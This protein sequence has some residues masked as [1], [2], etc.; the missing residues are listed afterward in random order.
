[1]LRRLLTLLTVLTLACASAQAY[2]PERSLL[3]QS[4]L[5]SPAKTAPR[6]FAAT[7]ATAAKEKSPVSPHSTKEKTLDTE[8]PSN[9]RR[10]YAQQRYYRPNLGR[11]NRIDPWEGDVLNPITLNKYLYAVGNPLRYTDP[12]G[13]QF[14]GQIC[15]AGYMYGHARSDEER[16]QALRHGANASP[17]IGVPVG[18]ALRATEIVQAPIDAVSDAAS[19][20]AGDE[21]AQARTGARI[22]SAL[23]AHDE[24]A[25]W[26]LAGQVGLLAHEANRLSRSVVDNVRRLSNAVSHNDYV[27]AGKSGVDLGLDITEVAGPVAAV[28]SGVVGGL[29][30]RRVARSEQSV[31]VVEGVDGGPAAVLMSPQAS[32]ASGAGEAA[33]GGLNLFRAGPDGSTTREAATGWRQGDRMLYL[34][35]QGSA[36]SNWVQNAGRLRQEMRAGEPIFD[37]YRDMA[38]GLQI[39]AGTSPASGGRFLNAERRLLESRGWIYDS[40]TGAYQPPIP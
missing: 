29:T 32:I 13:R 30:P 25:P 26:M 24:R 6:G 28:R 39:P 2:V 10:F 16:S 21:G 33:R 22:D 15:D 31:T 11:F 34:P 5:A 38:T 35:N 12:D 8:E 14:C 4:E 37:S 23:A 27:S 1:M 17:V 20:A 7:A 3:H 36:Q 18:A 40:S 19:A 9:G